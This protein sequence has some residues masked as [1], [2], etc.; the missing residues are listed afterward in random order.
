MWCVTADPQWVVLAFGPFLGDRAS[1]R[2]NDDLEATCD[3]PSQWAV[4]PETT[5]YFPQAI[6]QRK[7]ACQHLL[8]SHFLH[9]VLP[10]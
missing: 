6:A 5:I 3:T 4:Q 7:I 10:Q 8:L 9:A 2:T 1:K